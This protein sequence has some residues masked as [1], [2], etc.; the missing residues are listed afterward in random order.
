MVDRPP[1]APDEQSD[2]H[3]LT[4]K[5]QDIDLELQALTAGEVD[6]VIG[7]GG[8]SYL[9][10]Q[11]QLKLLRG[12]HEHRELMAQLAA[13]RGALESAQALGKIGSWSFEVSTSAVEWSL[14]MHRIFETDPEHFQPS[15]PAVIEMT[16]PED[17]ERMTG[18]FEHSLRSDENRVAE[19]RLL[20]PAEKVKYV[21]ERWQIERDAAGLAIHVRGTCQDITERRRD[22]QAL[23]QSQARLSMVTRLS[24]IGGWMI[25]VSKGVAWWSDEVCALLDVAPGTCPTLDEALAFYAPEWRESVGKARARCADAGITY[26]IEVE[27]I[28]ARGRRLWV[29]TIGE[30]VRDA[31]GAIRWLQGALQ[32]LSERKLAEQEV[33]R[34]AARLSNTL[35]SL[36][37]SF[38]TV[39]QD[40]RL[41][42]FNRE[43]ERVWKRRR[44]DVLGANLWI[45]FPELRG[46]AFE[47]GFRRAASDR[48]PGIVESVYP[49]TDSWFRASVHP[50]EEGI[51]V[52]LRDVTAERA[53]HR[54]LKLLESSVARLND[55]VLITEAVPLAEPGPRICFVND[56]L[57]RITGYSRDELL[58]VSPRILQGPETDRGELRR[59]GAALSRH[60]PVHAQLINYRKD[61]A[62]FWIELDI[63]PVAADGEEPS[64]FVAVERDITQRK[65][66]QDTLRNMNTE[67]EARVRSRTAD[68][69]AAR[70]EAEQANRAKSTFLATMSHEIRTPMNGV[71]G[72]VEV[73]AQ[74]ALQPAQFEMVR[75]IRES[76]DLLLA[77]IEDVLDFSKIEAGR[78]RIER[79]PIRIAHV[80]EGACALL[81]TVATRHDVGLTFFI[82]PRIPE[83]MLGDETRVRQVLNNLVGN[84]IKFSSGLESP[85]EVAVRVHCV[86]TRHDAVTVAISVQD[87]GIGI[88]SAT[89]ARLFTPFAQADE[90]TTRRFG[91]TG[92]GLAITHTLVRL[93]GGEISVRS[94]PEAGSTFTVQLTF[95]LPPTGNLRAWAGVDPQVR[96]LD[97]LMV[98]S[99]RSLAEDLSRYLSDAGATVQHY[100][101][102]PVA[103][104]RVTGIG[105]RLWLA[106]PQRPPISASSLRA[107]ASRDR[108]VRSHFLVLGRGHRRRPRREAAD[109]ISLDVDALTRQHLLS[110]VAIAAG[111]QPL[112]DEPTDAVRAPP[113]TQALATPMAGRGPILVAEDNATNREVILRQLQLLGFGSELVENGVQALE[114]WRSGKF[115]LVLTDLRM[116]VLDGYGLTARIRA[117]ETPGHRTVILALTANA[118]SEERERCR[119]AG[120]DGYLTKP[121]PLTVLRA[122]LDKWLPLPAVTAEVAVRGSAPEQFDAP[123]D[124]GALV[125][126]V[127]GDP[128]HMQAVLRSF[129]R[130]SAKARE[131]LRQAVADGDAP[132]AR[133]IAHKLKAGARSVGASELGETCAQLEQAA[134]SGQV[135]Q[136]AGLWERLEEQLIA[137]RKYL[138]SQL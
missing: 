87:N 130:S 93:M 33:R 123:A 19:H 114:R 21:E 52:Y 83:L 134:E 35:E 71:L 90:S 61:G 82:D 108:G 116:P 57:L 54:Q 104:L 103:Q 63:L 15:Y 7:P 60:E 46:S 1:D 74:S 77:L 32:D 16:H 66:D 95:E 135:E 10:Q 58:G 85:G 100:S 69:T 126:L 125:A 22:E 107:A 38:Y 98:G 131:Q 40:W 64:H 91:G 96:G 20:L 55:M 11:A 36:T 14:G 119:Q 112:P 18:Q 72:M 50:S 43:A 81:D 113:A 117:E 137:V 120:M 101:E 29:R 17:R 70:E 9:L 122:A 110:V 118:Q 34:L 136:F 97:I 56:A 84:A 30:P 42:Y 94:A 124:L 62:P 44:E 121:A 133:E 49:G 4:R 23:R 27:I 88:D 127:G 76:A 25:D 51:V 92:L 41:T 65:R 106:L 111:R 59:I 47:H 115:P 2:V 109:L 129:L 102:L 73:L 26:D 8:Q 39:D 128:A 67:L 37:V 31:T 105:E 80:I 78:L 24:R 138:D 89:L 99:D 5:L 12:E 6:A 79:A 86:A 48:Q 132:A 13:Q 75:L 53:E 3:A 68:L 28:T 45:E